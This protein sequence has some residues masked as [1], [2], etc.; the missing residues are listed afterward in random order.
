M[1]T[2]AS[3]AL[4][5]AA[6]AGIDS[7]AADSEVAIALAVAEAGEDGLAAVV[8]VAEGSEAAVGASGSFT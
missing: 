7:V 6:S 4:E 2:T 1:V 3:A 8:S 5:V